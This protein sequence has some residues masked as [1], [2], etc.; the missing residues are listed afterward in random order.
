MN[1]NPN[2]ISRSVVAVFVILPKV[3]EP[4]VPPGVPKVAW[5]GRLKNSARNS[6]AFD[7]L[8][9]VSLITEKSRLFQFGE[10]KV[11]RPRFPGVG[12]TRLPLIGLVRVG[13]PKYPVPS[14]FWLAQLVGSSPMTAS[15]KNCGPQPAFITEFRPAC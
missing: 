4:S 8:I 1:L 5:L 6:S 15:E 11:L 13:V 12:M 9:R 14:P 7:S 10:L 2:W 3:P